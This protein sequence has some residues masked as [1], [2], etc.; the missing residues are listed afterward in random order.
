MI[1]GHELPCKRGRGRSDAC[2]GPKNAPPL[3]ARAGQVVGPFGV[4]LSSLIM[5]ANLH[6]Q[7]LNVALVC[8]TAACADANN[9]L[10]LGV[11]QGGVNSA[12]ERRAFFGAQYFVNLTADG[13]TLVLIRPLDWAAYNTNDAPTL[14]AAIPRTTLNE[15]NP[16]VDNYRDLNA[17]F[18]DVE[19]GSA[20]TFAV[21]SNS[22]S[23]MVGATTPAN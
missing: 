14:A 17:V 15:D 1:L 11:L 13:I 9:D 23:S 22:N 21:Q 12:A 18:S 19:D 6:A 7:G 20:L 10:P 4:L 8:G 5:P 16:P 2:R 3:T